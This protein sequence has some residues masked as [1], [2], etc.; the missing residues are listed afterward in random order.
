MAR[1]DKIRLPAGQGGLTRY[2]EEA[3]STFEFSP[4][5]VIVIAIIIMLI[6]IALHNFWSF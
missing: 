2:F 5:S 3:K 6:I 1:D 4:S